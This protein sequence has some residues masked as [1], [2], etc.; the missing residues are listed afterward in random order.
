MKKL[1]IIILFFINYCF[2]GGLEND[3]SINNNIGFYLKIN[4]NDNILLSI[5]KNFLLHDNEPKL[6]DCDIR[7]FIPEFDPFKYEKTNSPNKI[8]TSLLFN[9]D[10]M[11]L[12]LSSWDK[13]DKTKFWIITASLVGLGIYAHDMQMKSWWSHDRGAFNVKEDWDY[14]CQ[15]D[16]IGHGYAA[17]VI[18]RT[19]TEAYTYSGVERGTSLLIGT[20]CGLSWQTYLEIMDGFGLTWGFSP[21]DFISDVIGATYPVAQEYF[22]PLR[23]FNFK[24]SYYPTPFLTTGVEQH[25]TLV[26]KANFTEDYAGQVYWLSV[27]IHEYLPKKM[28]QYWPDWLTI[29]VGYSLFNWDGE[30]ETLGYRVTDRELWLSFDYNLEKLPGDTK[31]INFLKKF[32]NQFHLPA[33]AVRLTPSVIWY[34]LFYAH[35]V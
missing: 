8:P 21:S 6:I 31:F 28:Q 14:A 11:S 25:G 13:V 10:P 2:S 20:L 27:N 4:S 29:A 5:D 33:P 32:F 7:Q 30:L 35:I 3:Y 23:N 12:N 15:L 26:K 19:I 34:G 22:K 1:F 9:D 24:F 18:S 16:K 17:M